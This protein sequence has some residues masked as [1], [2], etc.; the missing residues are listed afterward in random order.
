[1]SE[2]SSAASDAGR[3]IVVVVAHGSRS[4]AS[5]RSHLQL[6]ER[7]GERSG[8]DVA[9]AFLELAQPSIPAAIDQAAARADS[10]LVLPFFLH[11]GRHVN[12]DIPAL[13]A[14]AVERHPRVSIELL[15]T[16]GAEDGVLGLLSEQVVRATGHP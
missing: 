1:M 9:A 16:F 10:V 5:T 8:L 3:T 15:G 2:P 4:E 12:E 6:V 14:D 13:V 7:L 11:P